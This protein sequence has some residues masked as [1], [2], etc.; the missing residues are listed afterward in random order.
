MAGNEPRPASPSPTGARLDAAIMEVLLHRDVNAVTSPN[1]S[2]RGT[3]L[4]VGFRQLVADAVFA[5]RRRPWDAL[6]A[7]AEAPSQMASATDVSWSGAS[8]VK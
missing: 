1:D 5:G 4:P 6:M 8:C 3:N 2:L 7:F